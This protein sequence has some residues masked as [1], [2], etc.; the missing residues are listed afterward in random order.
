MLGLRH[1]R[2]AR[3]CQQRVGADLAIEIGQIGAVE[4]LVRDDDVEDRLS[5]PGVEVVGSALARAVAEP[6]VQ[7]LGRRRS[8][9]F[10][11]IGNARLQADAEL[12]RALCQCTG[13]GRGCEASA[14]LMP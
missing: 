6:P 3:P 14:A 10:V 12:L 5:L 9:Q 1:L 4:D 2:Q 8:D 13:Q 11:Q 7:Q